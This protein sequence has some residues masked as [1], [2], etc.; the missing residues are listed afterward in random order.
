MS[1][2]LQT[3]KTNEKLNKQ[4]LKSKKIKTNSIPIK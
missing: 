3:L 4:K 2:N 1:V